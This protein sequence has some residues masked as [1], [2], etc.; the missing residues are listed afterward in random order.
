MIL[1]AGDSSTLALLAN[2][3]PSEVRLKPSRSALLLIAVLAL[4]TCREAA[5][6]QHLFGTPADWSV[7]PP[8][9]R[10]VL[11]EYG[12]YQCPPCVTLHRAVGEVQAKHGHEIRFVFRHY[13]TK[14]HRNALRAAEAAEAA[15]TQG[16]FWQMHAKLYEN[17]S[18]WYGLSDPMP[19]FG[20][21]ARDIGLDVT[22]FNSD[23]ESKRY[24]S[25]INE[26]KEQAQQLGVRGAPALYINGDRVLKLPLQ[27]NDLNALVVDALRSAP[28][29]RVDDSDRRRK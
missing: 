26:S 21:Y 4:S 14:R 25:K 6:P 20:R 12:D 18:E 24:Q 11:L 15:G 1:C 29:E 3:P 19:A 5:P 22:H 17:Q 16:K 27:T 23:V 7:G 10:V 2:P 9:P 28:A 13:P 8:K